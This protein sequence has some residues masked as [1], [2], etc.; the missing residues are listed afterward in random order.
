MGGG[1]QLSCVTICIYVLLRMGQHPK[2]LSWA[3][4]LDLLKP[5]SQNNEGFFHFQQDVGTYPVAPSSVEGVY[6]PL[7]Y[8][9]SN[10]AIIQRFIYFIQPRSLKSISADASR[11]FIKEALMQLQCLITVVFKIRLSPHIED[12]LGY[13]PPLTAMLPEWHLLNIT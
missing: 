12:P 7:T 10:E 1:S 11:M 13:Q 8:Q 6:Y 9:Y 3:H 5:I 2:C 4:F